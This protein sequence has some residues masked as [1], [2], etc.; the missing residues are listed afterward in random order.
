MPKGDRAVLHRNSKPRRMQ[1]RLS[2]RPSIG[3]KDGVERLS[4]REQSR[5]IRVLISGD[6]IDVSVSV[7]AYL[8]LVST[9]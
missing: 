2:P 5:C 7:P 8:T 3:V 6:E 9:P 1:D 4:A